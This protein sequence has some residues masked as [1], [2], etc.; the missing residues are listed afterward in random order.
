MSKSSI[1]PLVQNKDY[2]VKRD[3][4]FSKFY[5][6]VNQT[7]HGFTTRFFRAFVN[8]CF[9]G[10]WEI[11]CCFVNLLL[12]VITAYKTRK[13]HT[14]H[15]LVLTPWHENK[16]KFFHIFL[17]SNFINAG[18]FNGRDFRHFLIISLLVWNFNNMNTGREEL[19][20]M[21]SWWSLRGL[22]KKRQNNWKIQPFFIT[23]KPSPQFYYIFFVHF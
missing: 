6:A 2:K 13:K 10:E 7:F 14:I 11:F 21:R 22:K 17:C 4:F 8:G 15:F 1:S 19:W 3:I 5:D 9:L 16:Y 23:T 20:M 12:L 18:N